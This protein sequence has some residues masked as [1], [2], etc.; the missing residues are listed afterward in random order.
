[1]GVAHFLN[2]N[3]GGYCLFPGE[4]PDRYGSSL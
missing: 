1:M 2:S 3:Y 4:N